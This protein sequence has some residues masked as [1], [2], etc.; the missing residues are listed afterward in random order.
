M[1]IRKR[2]QLFVDFVTIFVNSES[3][4]STKHPFFLGAISHPT[5]YKALPFTSRMKTITVYRGN[6]TKSGDFIDITAPL[7]PSP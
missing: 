7:T 3:R 2:E 4:T 6:H 1:K 5:P